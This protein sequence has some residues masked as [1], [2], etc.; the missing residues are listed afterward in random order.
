M[1]V[2]KNKYEFYIILYTK[3]FGS[4]NA[5][6]EKKARGK[7]LITGMGFKFGMMTEYRTQCQPLSGSK[8][9]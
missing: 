5:E 7:E 9:S 1:S 4:W 8:A 2:R 3:K 6:F